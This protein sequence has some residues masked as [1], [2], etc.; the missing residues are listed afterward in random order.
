[1][2]W[3][4]S[5]RVGETVDPKSRWGEPHPQ[6]HRGR[7]TGVPAFLQVIAKLE[8]RRAGL[9]KVAHN[10]G[11]DPA[12]CATSFTTAT[13]VAA[14]GLRMVGQVG[15]EPTTD[16]LEVRPGPHRRLAIGRFVRRSLRLVDP[17]EQRFLLFCHKC[18]ARSSRLFGLRGSVPGPLPISSKGNQPHA[19]PVAASITSLP[20]VSDGSAPR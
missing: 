8:A 14:L 6:H 3:T 17:A 12:S 20:R 4:G 13:L 2:R 1:M 15:L 18:A 7:R 16:G 11:L 9:V 10:A 19:G 5:G